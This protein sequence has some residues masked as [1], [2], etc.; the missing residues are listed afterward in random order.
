MYVQNVIEEIEL[1]RRNSIF[2][3]AIDVLDMDEWKHLIDCFQLDYQRYYSNVFD[4]TK[5]KY[6]PGLVSTFFYRIS[7]YLFLKGLENEAQEFSSCGYDNSGMEIYF[8]ANIGSALK[9]NHGIGTIIG[10]RVTLGDNV[11]L[12]HNVTFGDKNGYRPIIGNC[13]TVY[14]G[15]VIVG[16]I[17]IGDNCIIGANTFVD[18]SYPANSIIK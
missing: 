5:I 18:K 13:V 11:L 3:P 10:A 16:D 8:S 4:A 7:R 6:F 15:A 9:I 14:P 17:K 2:K 1:F 12:H